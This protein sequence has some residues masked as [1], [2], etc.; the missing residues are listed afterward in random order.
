MATA[1]VLADDNVADVPGC[2]CEASMCKK[3]FHDISYNLTT[4]ACAFGHSDSDNFWGSIDDESEPVCDTLLKSEDF[5]DTYG[6]GATTWD[7]YPSGPLPVTLFSGTCDDSIKEQRSC[8][9]GDVNSIL[10][11]MISYGVG[12]RGV[13]LSACDS[14]SQMLPGTNSTLR[15]GLSCASRYD[16]SIATSYDD[17]LSIFVETEFDKDVPLC[18]VE[19]APVLS[20]RDWI[21]PAE[22][23]RYMCYEFVDPKD[24][25]ATYSLLTIS[26]GNEPCRG[27][28][29]TE[30]DINSVGLAHISRGFGLLVAVAIALIR[31]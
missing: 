2:N 14:T 20:S 3:S 9:S 25:S 17:Q 15:W 18:D 13:G 16:T 5:Q 4:M 8:K 6:V 11:S 31:V 23:R 27:P 22:G 7:Y 28:K 30:P 19:I 26:L 12:Y 21:E 10:N 29:P 1:S 24:S